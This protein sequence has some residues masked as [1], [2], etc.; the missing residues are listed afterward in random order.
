MRMIGL[1][2]VLAVG[3]VAAPLARILWKLGRGGL[4]KGGP[5]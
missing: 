2:V 4:A 5:P 3:L 1:A